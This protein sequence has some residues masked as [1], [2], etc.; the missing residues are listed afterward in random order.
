MT[1][2]DESEEVGQT[3]PVRGKARRPYVAPSI[4][5]ETIFERQAV[6]A[7]GK[8]QQLPVNPC[9]NRTSAS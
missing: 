5:T 8:I 4:E 2:H 9:T 1:K 7:C 6:M 3:K